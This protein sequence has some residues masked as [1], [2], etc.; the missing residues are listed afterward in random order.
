MNATDKITIHV[1]AA[2]DD[3]I[4][5]LGYVITGEVS[6]EGNKF[7]VGQYTSMEA[8]LHALLEGVRLATVRSN[9]REMCEVYTDCQPLR[10]KLCGSQ[11]ESGDWHEYR[12]SA[13]W[14][15]DKFDSWE[16]IH[17]SRSHN[18]AAHNLAREALEA[19][20]QSRNA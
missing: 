9:S 5:G 2:R 7:L 11:P 13:H 6:H 17:T 18:E 3:T 12:M 4:S 15:L 14:L 20:R 16:V 1:D 19:G 8:E 10:T